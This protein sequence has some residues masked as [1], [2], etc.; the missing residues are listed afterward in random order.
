[1]VEDAALRAARLALTQGAR[2]VL[3]TGLYLLG[4]Q[5]PERM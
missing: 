4:L 2:D 5:A 1:M 3:R